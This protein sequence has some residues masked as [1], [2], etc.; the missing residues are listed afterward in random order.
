[1][2]LKNKLISRP[3]CLQNLHT[4]PAGFFAFIIVGCQLVISHRL[5]RKHSTLTSPVH[6]SQLSVYQRFNNIY[7]YYKVIRINIQHGCI[8][9]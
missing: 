5:Q 1:M 4:V 8:I 7:W 2:R 3:A 9:G 6:T